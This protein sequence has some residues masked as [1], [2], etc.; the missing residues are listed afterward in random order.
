VPELAARVVERVSLEHADLDVAVAFADGFPLVSADPDRLEQVLTNL[1]EN[2]AKYASPTGIRLEGRSG[3]DRITISVSDDGPGIPAVD[4]P[5]V[6]EK[7]YRRDRSRPSGI[8]LGLW[9]SRGVVEAHGGHLT[10]TSQS[11]QGSTFTLTIPVEA[12][13]EEKGLDGSRRWKPA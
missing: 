3:N 9:I 5:K 8:G 13:E 2:A 6:F 1:V 11:G 12:P 10:V 7:F 4:L